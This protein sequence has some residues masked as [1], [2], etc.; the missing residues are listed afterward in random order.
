MLFTTQSTSSHWHPLVPLARALEG[1]GHEVAF[2]ATPGFCA[3]IEAK[4]FRCFPAGTAETPEERQQ[5]KER[6][7]GL[8]GAEETFFLL[9]HVFAGFTA[10][11]SLPDLLDIIAH[12]R[13]SV[14]V[15]ENTE[16]AGCIAAERAGIPHA[17]VQITAALP[18][19]QQAV[20][21]PIRRLC[22]SVG[23]PSEQAADVSGLL[24]RHLLLFPRP[25]SLWDPAVPVP[26]TTHTFR[27]TGFSQSGE[28]TLPKWVAELDRHGKRPTVYATL[29]TFDNERT[30]ILAAILE[31]L[32]DEP[33]NLIL[34]VGRNR[35]PQ[36]FGEQPPNVRV[37][38]YIPHNLLLP[39]C[40]LVLCHG[41]SG[42]IMDALSRGLPLLILPIAADQ[43]Q[44]AQRCLEAGVARVVEPDPPPQSGLPQAI[45]AATREVLGDPRYKQAAQRLR[46]EIEE[47]PGLEYPVAL[48]EK[49]AAGPAP[50]IV[51][52]L[53]NS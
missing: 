13:A 48:L 52:P 18:Y 51:E 50:L 23:L 20:E 47:M 3:T 7:A 33:L 43:P 6:M 25:L 40:D 9:H 16:F 45:R 5:R 27:Y 35:D 14:V 19:F 4:G 1:A 10:E 38:R 31:A 21:D 28:E 8:S 42:T 44:N 53:V 17:A 12:W 11:R 2:A 32:R 37:E 26:P 30:D 15:R 24:Y 22:A 46:Q 49:L 41:G 34:T 36:E 39:Y 29:G